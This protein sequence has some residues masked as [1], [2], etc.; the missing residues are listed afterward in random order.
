MLWDQI[1]ILTLDSSRA[2]SLKNTQKPLVKI[3][4]INSSDELIFQLDNWAKFKH[5][6]HQGITSLI[7]LVNPINSYELTINWLPI[8]QSTK[9]LFNSTQTY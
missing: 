8:I 5:Q 2:P 9:S 7:D 3:N 4:S 6:Q 1:C